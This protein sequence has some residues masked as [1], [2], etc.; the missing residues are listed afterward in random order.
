[1]NSNRDPRSGKGKAYL[2]KEVAVKTER[3]LRAERERRSSIYFGFGMFGLVGWSVVIPTI[4][5]ITLGLWIDFKWPSRVPWTLTL[6]LA[7]VLLGG[8][9]AWRWVEQERRGAPRES[10]ASENASNDEHD[11]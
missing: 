9:N 7:G 11:D 2:P 3:K 6:M 10:A 5:G 4:L 8:Y 1:M